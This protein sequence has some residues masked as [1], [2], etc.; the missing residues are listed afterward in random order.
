[1]SGEGG[2]RGRGKSRRRRRGQVFERERERRGASSLAR[3][4]LRGGSREEK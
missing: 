1:M 3:M 4:Q 2:K